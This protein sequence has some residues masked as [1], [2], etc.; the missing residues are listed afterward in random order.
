MLRMSCAPNTRYEIFF[1][2][3]HTSKWACRVRG[4]K[5]GV[6]WD[7]V[8]AENLLSKRGVWREEEEE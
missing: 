5:R 6:E 1:W 3:S 4:G 7:V 2:V 8:G